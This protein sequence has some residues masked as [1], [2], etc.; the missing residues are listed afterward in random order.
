VSL[1]RKA[2]AAVQGIV[3]VV[4][5]SG[6]LARPV[7]AVLLAIALALLGWSFGRDVA[8]LWRHRRGAEATSGDRRSSPARR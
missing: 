4:A 7:A 5:C 6:V 1:A 2:V 3:L 8:W